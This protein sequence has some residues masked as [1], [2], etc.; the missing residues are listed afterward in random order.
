[1][2]SRANGDSLAWPEVGVKTRFSRHYTENGQHGSI[3][4]EA[5]MMHRGGA[6]LSRRPAR[7]VDSGSG[8]GMTS[9][10]FE[11]QLSHCGTAD[12]N[13]ASDG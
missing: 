2:D 12:S 5:P 3:P 8:A 6:L 13:E 4:A 9:L 7:F 1:M 10:S 11:V